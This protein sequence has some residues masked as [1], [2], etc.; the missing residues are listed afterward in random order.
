MF[1]LPISN[2]IYRMK[3]RRDIESVSGCVPAYSGLL[4]NRHLLTLDYDFVCVSMYLR[5]PSKLQ[6]H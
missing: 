6:T 3:R 1:A 4:P 2:D 5:P